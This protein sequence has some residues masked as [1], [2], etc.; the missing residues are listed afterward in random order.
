MLFKLY[1]YFRTILYSIRVSRPVKVYCLLCIFHY[2]INNA[3]YNT[4]DIILLVF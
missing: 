2:I 1:K 4:K 3:V